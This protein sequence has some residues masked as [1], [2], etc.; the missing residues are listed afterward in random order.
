[1]RCYTIQQNNSEPGIYITW[2]GNHTAGIEIGSNLLVEA[3][4]LL[5]ENII[6]N[7]INKIDRIS[8]QKKQDNWFLVKEQNKDQEEILIFIREK[9]FNV[10]NTTLIIKT[11]KDKK[12]PCPN[13][14]KT[15]NVTGTNRCPLCDVDLGVPI[16]D[17]PGNCKYL[18]PDNGIAYD[19]E[20]K[21]SSNFYASSKHFEIARGIHK[22]DVIDDEK[23]TVTIF[24]WLGKLSKGI[25][26]ELNITGSSD[27]IYLHW[28]GKELDYWRNPKEGTTPIQI[29]NKKNDIL[30]E[31]PKFLEPSQDIIFTDEQKL[32]VHHDYGPALVFAVAG[33]GKTT[34]LVYR[35]ERLV[36]EGLFPPEKILVSSF[37]KMA[38]EEIHSKLR[39]WSCC[40]PVDVRTLHSLGLSILK[41]ARL[42]KNIPLSYSYEDPEALKKKIVFEAI[43]IARGKNVYYGDI[44]D[45][46]D[47]DD[48]L[49]Y[50]EKCKTNIDYADLNEANLPNQGLQQATQAKAPQNLP[51]YLDLYRL[52]EE[53]RKTNNWI[54]YDDM[55]LEGWESLISYPEI[56]NFFR[57]K[58][59]CVLIDEFQDI[60]KV[61]HAILDLL[62]DEHR[63]YMAIG[64]DDQTIY[65]WRGADPNYIIE[66]EKRYQAKKY[67]LSLN[68]RSTATQVLLANEVIQHNKI[69]S[70]KTL[71]LYRTEKGLSQI[72]PAQNP[73]S[74]VNDIVDFFH[75]KFNEGLL[76]E[77]IVILVRLYSQTPIIESAFIK[78]DI[79]YQ[80]IGNVPFYQRGEIRLFLDYLRIGLYE[81][82]ISEKRNFEIDNA[83]NA[84]M[85]IYHQPPRYIKRKVARRIFEQVKEKQDTFSNTLKYHAPFT[86]NSREKVLNLA[87]HLE[88]LASN[89]NN[90][91]PSIL[92]KNLDQKM[93]ISQYLMNR[94]SRLEKK[95]EIQDEVR[96]FFDYCRD[97]KNVH[98]LLEHFDTLA[99][100]Q[101]IHKNS[102][103]RVTIM[104]IHQAKGKEW[105]YVL[106]PHV[107]HGII[108]F[109]GNEI[110]EEE[111]RL[112]Y[113]AVTRAKKF[114]NIYTID[115]KKPSQFL[116][117][118]DAEKL[119]QSF[120]RTESILSSD[121]QK[122]SFEDLLTLL[123]HHQ[124][125]LYQKI[126][127]PWWNSLPTDWEK[128]FKRLTRLLTYL[129]RIPLNMNIS[130]PNIK[131]NL[132]F[133]IPQG[134]LYPEEIDIQEFPGIEKHINQEIQQKIKHCFLSEEWPPK[135]KVIHSNFGEGE[136]IMTYK[137]KTGN[138]Y[139]DIYF[140]THGQK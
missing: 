64:D 6:E 71:H 100:S 129:E 39:R 11:K 76:S 23:D 29:T 63:N 38:V 85:N 5:Y 28:S 132:W 75:K 98:E 51:W 106:I 101:N 133:E 116:S 12:A 97:F 1:M 81:L 45:N 19:Y 77:D 65:Q 66:F 91:E 7:Q 68:F 54:T 130:I 62:I 20:K 18:H 59:S 16:D 2:N 15:I 123:T 17:Y 95:E 126:L 105:D 114:L 36:R 67:I 90:D 121:I 127:A 120:Y 119:L 82:F 93:K 96:N 9:L 22:I 78:N 72:I 138:C 86:G 128:L 73:Q 117:E 50:V 47:I 94:Y 99:E 109:T 80:I 53:V 3:S 139:L 10:D 104:S 124:I 70:K 112:F 58:Y 134:Q 55:L 118:T 110:F 136:V 87:E 31:D 108:P 57:Q 21:N 14:V 61:Q 43:K 60:N 122:A 46:L 52:Y 83:W 13:R 41:K 135:K 131:R 37:N 89:I 4:G 49:S 103:R 30:I 48:F 125:K 113:V 140:P 115:S 102:S 88:W 27:I 111:R 84:W 34:C 26:Y 40:Q 137:G 79:D 8:I 56:L 25:T 69:R 35:I 24:E 44:L 74:M 32:V 107:N 42:Q 92:L 33:S